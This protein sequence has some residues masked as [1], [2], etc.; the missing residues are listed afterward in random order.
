MSSNDNNAAND[1]PKHERPFQQKFI[2]HVYEAVKSLSMVVKSDGLGS[3][4]SPFWRL[5]ALVACLSSVLVNFN[6]LEEVTENLF[7]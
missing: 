6:G 5:L 7:D 4:A 1:L 3:L 2:E